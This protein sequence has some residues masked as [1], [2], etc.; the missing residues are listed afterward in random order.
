MN[1]QR[2]DY[3]GS[4]RR[5]EIASRVPAFNSFPVLFPLLV[6]LFLS[7][8]QA[9]C[10]GVTGGSKT[11]N[12]TTSATT[13]SAPSSSPSSGPGSSPS[14]SVLNANTANLSF[15]NV[16]VGTSSVQGVTLTNGGNSNITISNVSISGAGFTASGVSTGQILTAG[17]TAMLDLTFAPSATVGV[18][19]SVT[20]TSNASNSPATVSVSGAGAQAAS[21]QVT[22]SW[23]SGA[24]PVSGYN[25]YRSPVSGGPYSKLDSA[26]IAA[27]QYVDATVQAGQTYYYV[28]TSVNS[29]GQESAY[30]NVASATVPSS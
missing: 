3:C 11:S 9:G 18:T 23:N 24:T 26:L 2:L 28:V 19:G 29:T 16:K 27:T 4:A 13:V 10:V 21:S 14:T 30:S 5:P 20:V 7:L 25:V 8:T 22:L 6:V 17:Q 1:T 15:G 12:W